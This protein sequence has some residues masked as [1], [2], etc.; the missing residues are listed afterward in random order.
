M[1]L[2]RRII[3]II[4][5]G[6]LLAALGLAALPQPAS[7]Q[8]TVEDAVFRT[9]SR[10]LGIS[11]A[12]TRAQLELGSDDLPFPMS[13]ETSGLDLNPSNGVPTCDARVLGTD[14]FIQGWV[15]YQ[16]SVRV[17][18]NGPD[19]SYT[20]R[21][22]GNGTQ[23]IRCAGGQ[24]VGMDFGGSAGVGA[25]LS[26][27]DLTDRAMQHL[28]GFLD[29]SPAITRA[30]VDRSAEDP[31]F[32]YPYR[33]RYRWDSWL[34]TNS[35]LN[36]P[37]RNGTWTNGDTAAYRIILTVNGRSYQYRSTLDGSTLILCLG[38][39]ADPSSLGITA[40]AATE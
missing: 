31:D 20:F 13:Y 35:Q 28:S 38:G 5:G 27:W 9:V 26:G 18:S 10:E 25:A 29:L 30:D 2:I 11:P 34:Y 37:A 15:G 3:M 33:A 16:V 17:L 8:A 39:R 36:C 40:A 19:R 4:L 6:G 12:P 14:E 21:T 22:N 1:F 23:I 24:E 7:A 32:E